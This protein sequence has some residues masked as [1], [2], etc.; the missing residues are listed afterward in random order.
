M[1]TKNIPAGSK[2]VYYGPGTPA[3]TLVNNFTITTN[4]SGQVG[5]KNGDDAVNIYGVNGITLVNTGTINAT[6]SSVN[7]NA[8]YGVQFDAKFGLPA[9]ISITNTATGIIEDTGGGYGFGVAIQGGTLVNDGFISGGSGVFAGA[10]VVVGNLGTYISNASTGTIAGGGIIDHFGSVN[11]VNAGKI[12]GFTASNTYGAIYLTGGGSV[13][14]LSTGTISPVGGTAYGIKI[15]AGAGTVTNAGYINGG[16]GDAVSLAAGYTNLVVVDPGA[17]FHGIVNGGAAAQST[18]ELGSGATTGTLTGFNSEY[19]NFGTL[20]FAPSAQWLFETNTANIPGVINGFVQGDTIDITGFTATSISTLSGNKGV[21]LNRGATHETISFGG[22]ISNFEFNTGSFGTDLTTICFCVDTLIGTPDGEVPV[23]TLQ[24]GDMVLTA[25]N[26][27]RKVIW[28]GIGKVLAT[29]GK[30]G[31]ATPVIVRRGALADNVPH[32]DLHV[33]KAHSLYIG[34]VLIPVEFLVNHR[35]IVWDDRAQEVEIYHVELESHDVLIANGVPA[36]SFRDD[37]N[38]WLFQNARSGGDLPPQEPY[39]PVLTGGPVVDTVWRRLLDRAGP[40]DALSL[41]DDPDLHLII[42][43]IRVDAR[44]RRDAGYVF[45][46][47]NIPRSVIVASRVGVP[48][49]LGIA[50]D[51]RALGV[52]FFRLTI[53]QGAKFMLLDAD[54]ERLTAGFHE[55][56]PEDRLRWT[57]GYAELPIEAFARF[58]EGAEVILHLGGATRYPDSREDARQVGQNETAFWYA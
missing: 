11:I 22:T 37:G 46:L 45:R 8:G 9:T 38:R 53:R 56:E 52:A 54:D 16:G 25:H 34:E 15:A 1:T 21:V 2:G 5:S 18:L 13:A 32:Q 36:E 30:R 47:P 33:T 23:Q 51:P 35:T 20:T 3:E 19:I 50:R 7:G 41:T 58:D 27:P 26:G 39:A 40:C 17:R 31:V 49:E 42:D 57:D 29:R 4:P 43:G 24:P 55:Y 48:S 6:Y 14:N 44:E 28:V 12:L 10:G